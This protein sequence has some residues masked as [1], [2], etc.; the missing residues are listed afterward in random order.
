MSGG[1][2]TLITTPGLINTDFADVK[3]ILS[4]AGSALMGIGQAISEGMVDG[5]D[6]ARRNAHLLDYKLQTASD[7]PVMH[8]DFVDLPTPNAGPF[9]SK[10]VGEPCT[11]PTPG[12]IANAIAIAIGRRVHQLPATPERVWSV[13]NGVEL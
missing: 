6:G 12:A 13:A 11:V 1:I 7:T 3:I 5:A 10:G 2:T 8:V 9:G 4:G